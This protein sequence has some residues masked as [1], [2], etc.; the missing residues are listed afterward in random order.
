MCGIT[1]F[2]L[3]AA[4][5]E[6]VLAAMTRTLAHRGPDG[7]GYF[8]HEG[9]GLGHRRLSI[10]DV[11][12]G[13][14]P[15]GNEDGSVQI[16]FNGE[17][18]NF[19]ELAEGLKARGH[20]FATRS[21]TE[22]L[23]HLYEE[24]GDAFLSRLNGIFAFALYDRKRRRLLLARDP[25]GVKPLYYAEVPGG[26][27]FGSELK[28]LL[29]FPGFDRS[30]DPEALALYLT[31]EYLPA[32]LTAFRTAKKLPPGHLLAVE[33]GKVSLR[34]YWEWSP[35]ANPPRT[36]N[37]AADAVRGL[38]RSAVSSQLLSDVP[39]GVFL[40][41]GVDS[42]VVT[43]AMRAAGA[44]TRSFSIGF[45]DPRFDESAEARLA[46]S[47]LGCD[48]S[49]RRF[50]EAELMEEVPRLM[51]HMDEPFADPSVF[52]TALLSRFTRKSVTVA[53]GGDGGDE[54]FGGYPTYWVHRDYRYYRALPSFLR[55]GLLSAADAL[56]PVEQAGLT[57]SYKLRK[58]RDGAERQMPWRHLCWMGAF[59]PELAAKLFPGAQAALERALAWVPPPPADDP[60]TAARWLD[61]HTY[62]AE[63]ILAKVDRASMAASLEARVPL[64]DPEVVRLAFSLPP[65]LLFQGR[66]GKWPLRRAFEAE[67]P[68]GFFNRPKR[69]F[70]IPLSRW[71]CGPL[72]PFAEELL[73][74][75]TLQS[76][77]LA[78][79]ALPLR[80]WKEHLCGKADH[81]KPLWAY[82]CLAHWFKKWKVA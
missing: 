69:G 61:F 42:T 20:R 23:V 10:I 80:L 65:S 75:E 71:L 39:L 25:V 27:L 77:P 64:L 26:L 62:L 6:G 16:V 9:V 29:A 30:H 76:L 53:L 40:S 3:T 79:K 7:E 67:L 22:V 28:A 44:Q 8:A 57:F 59:R 51:D 70:G 19:R 5:A 12:G 41:G 21:D 49:S 18:Y 45:D 60:A 81:R 11:A 63:D 54:L 1:G 68:K 14:Q 73:S 32:P 56:L 47:H 33:C 78:D 43:A 24:E 35:L 31:C 66:R 72:R 74:S 13:A 38:V 34:R 48:H 58:F 36:R 2:S 82:F 50:S 52:P 55:K 17:I 4:P 37:E 15:L 46:G